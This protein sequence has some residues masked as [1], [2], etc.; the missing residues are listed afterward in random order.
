MNK[1]ILTKISDMKME[2]QVIEAAS[3]YP[4]RL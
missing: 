2:A 4:I 1:G 3:G